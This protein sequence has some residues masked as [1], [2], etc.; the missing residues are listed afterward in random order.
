MLII[1]AFSRMSQV[2][3][4]A[5]R[6]YDEIGLLKPTHVDGESGYRYYAANLLPRLNR[7]LFLKELGFSLNEIG[8]VLKGDLP[9]ATVRRMLRQQLRTRQ[10]RLEEEQRRLAQITA[11]LAQLEHAERL[12]DYEVTIKEVAPRW[13]ASMRSPLDSYA[14]AGQLFAE[15][16][17]YLEGQN[18]MGPHGAIWHACTGREQKIDCEALVL[19]RRPVVASNQVRVYELP[20]ASVACVIHQG[21]DETCSQAY[22]TAR[23]WIKSQGHTVTGPNRELY[24]NDDTQPD[25]DSSVTEI[26]FPIVASPAGVFG[27]AN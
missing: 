9:L 2:S 18:T 19:L 26:Q 11:W 23:T 22:M 16:D 20:A 8:Q 1:G 17:E 3:I 12:P 6:F 25:G 4:K 21:N 24:W 14:D 7:M 5:L 27:H 13:V 15:L 10:R